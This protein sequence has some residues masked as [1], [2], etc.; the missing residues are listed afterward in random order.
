MAHKLLKYM[1]SIGL[2]VDGAL[3]LRKEQKVYKKIY[4]YY[5]DLGAPFSG[6][7]D[8]DYELVIDCL[9]EDLY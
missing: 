7:S 1:D 6:D 4:K 5:K 8:E 3:D 9:Y 2:A